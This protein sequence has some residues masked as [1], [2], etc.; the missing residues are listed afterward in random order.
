MP[1][2]ISRIASSSAR[3]AVGV[4]GLDDPLDVAV[5]VADDRGRRRRGR[6]ARPSSPS[7]RRRRRGGSRAGRRSISAETSGWSPE[8]TTTVSESRDQ[9]ERGAH[10]AAGAVGLRLDRRSRCRRAGPAE[11]S[12]SGETI[13]RDPPG[14]GLARGEHRP[15]DHRPP[16]DRVQ[17]LRQ[18][19]AHAR[20]LA[21]GH[22]QDGGPAHPRNRSARA[23]RALSIEAV[24]ATWLA[25]G[26]ARSVRDVDVARS[27]GAREL[28]LVDRDP[29]ADRVV[30]DAVPAA[31]REVAELARSR[32]SSVW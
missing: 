17:D 25:A 29:L 28:A 4:L 14:A 31:D 13:T 7:P 30:G 6:R 22:D 32:A 23:A 8:R 21:G 18:R 24:T 15:G 16:A 5:G 9:V 3:D 12:R 20:A 19:G 11:R 27:A 10:G 1:V 2:L 26:Q